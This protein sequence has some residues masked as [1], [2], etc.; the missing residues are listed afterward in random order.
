MKKFRTETLATVRS[1][2]PIDDAFFRLIG[3][4]KEVCQ[5]ILR[6]L[7]SDEHLI[8]LSAT[9]QERI[10]SL[11]REIV[12]DVLCELGDGKLVNIEVQVGSQNDDVKRCRFHLASITSSKTPKNTFFHDVPDVV[13]VYI[14]EYD[15]FGN[16]QAVTCA[17]MCQHLESGYVPVNDGAKIYYA[18]TAVNDNTDKSELLSL[19]LQTDSFYNEKFPNLSE[20]VRY[21]KEDESG[22]SK[23]CTIVEEYAKEYAKEL[24]EELAKELAIYMIK[25]GKSTSEIAEVTHLTEEEINSLRD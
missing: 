12:L 16:G 25:D 9:P 17:E 21:F 3:A 18:N 22:V 20:A 7:L 19:L 8:V 23:M 5:D 15:V 6:T 14:T 2:R 13:I 4:R 24:T 1:L 10:T 11:H